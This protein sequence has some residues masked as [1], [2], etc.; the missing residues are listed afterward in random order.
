MRIVFMIFIYIAAI[1]PL[2]SFEPKAIFKQVGRTRM[3]SKLFAF[4]KIY[5]KITGF[6]EVVA[7]TNPLTSDYSEL[8]DSFEGMTKVAAERFDNLMRTAFQ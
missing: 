8:P 4:E 6:S 2:L 3:P 1:S 7:E 5:S